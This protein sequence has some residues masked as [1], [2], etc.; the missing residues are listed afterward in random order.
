MP[1]KKKAPLMREVQSIYMEE[2]RRLLTEIRESRKRARKMQ[3]EINRLK[4]KTQAILN[5]L[6]KRHRLIN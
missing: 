6:E 5:R 4:K 2:F 3:V 1:R